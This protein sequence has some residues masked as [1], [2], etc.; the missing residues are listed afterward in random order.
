[1]ARVRETWLRSLIG[2]PQS[3]LAEADGTGHAPNFARFAVP[4]GTLRGTL[5]T[6]SP[7]RLV[8]GLLR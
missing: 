5:V 3:V 7:V 1:V 4:P 8:E 2:Q 6:V